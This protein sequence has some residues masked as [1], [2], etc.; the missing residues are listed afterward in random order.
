MK[1]DQ[2]NREANGAAVGVEDPD[3]FDDNRFTVTSSLP[4]GSAPVA[5]RFATY[6]DSTFAFDAEAFR[7]GG[8][9]AMLMD[10][11]QRVLLEEIALAVM[12]AGLSVDALQGSSVGKSWL[13]PAPCL[14]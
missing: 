8:N 7:L 9:E 4:A 13:K 2:L 11:Q 3:C 1:T 5:S 12:D 6:V 14:M 10:P